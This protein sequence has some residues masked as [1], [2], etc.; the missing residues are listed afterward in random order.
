MVR[1]FKLLNEKGQSYSLMDIQKYCLLTEPS[2]LG[3]SFQ[4]EYEQIGYTFIES[5]RTIQQ[6]PFNG[7]LNFLSY[8]NYKKFTDFCANSESLKLAYK[9]PFSKKEKEYLKD[10]N[11]Q[12][13]GKTQKQPN[14]VI[15]EP[16]VFDCLS[17]WYEENT[18]I[19]TIEPQEDEFKWDITWDSRFKDY[20]SQSIIYK[21]EGH[22]E[23]PI[24]LEIDGDVNNPKI[25]V[26]IDNKL[27]QSIT[28]NTT[29]EEY[30]KLLYNSK[31]NEFYINKQ[32]TDGSIESLFDLDIIDFGNDNVIR[33]PKGMLCNIV[34]SADNT[35]Q[36]AKLTILPQF[37][38]V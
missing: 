29:I 38:A 32:N 30:E 25:E 14:G 36:R 22:I 31:E 3:H 37:F 20:N 1:E 15:S 23:A 24:L 26:Y 5:I 8:D 12:S 13:I 18:A 9:I 16:V 7:T 34:V 21:N 6:E 4:T 17:L 28:I 33:L 19:Y 10:V 27:Y 35:I 11:L 2:G